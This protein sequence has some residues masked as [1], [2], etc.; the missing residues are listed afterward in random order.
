MQSRK[1]GTGY[2]VR[3]KN[4][5]WW[6]TMNKKVPYLVYGFAGMLFFS[7]LLVV[8][9]VVSKPVLTASD[10]PVTTGPLRLLH[11]FP[12]PKTDPDP[13]QPNE[14]GSKR[15]R[16]HNTVFVGGAYTRSRP[17][18]VAYRIQVIC[19]DKIISLFS[20]PEAG[21][22]RKVAWRQR[23]AERCSEVSMDLAFEPIL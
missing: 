5:N 1:E 2:T 17:W 20:V 22:R 9:R 19:L 14:C 8:S 10:I 3:S 15:I 4:C 12:V 13:R 18:D 23:R 21:L 11:L 6:T 16:I 7:N